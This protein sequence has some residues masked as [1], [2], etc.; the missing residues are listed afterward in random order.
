MTLIRD[1][2]WRQGLGERAD[3]VQEAVDAN[4]DLDACRCRLEV[5]MSGP[6]PGH[7]LE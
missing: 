5:N 7:V 3:L 2:T 6:P 4:P 1:L